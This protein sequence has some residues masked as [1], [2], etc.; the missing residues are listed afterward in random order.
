MF[1][2]LCLLYRQHT[3]LRSKLKWF[4]DLGFCVENFKVE[5]LIVLFTVLSL[6]LSYYKVPYINDLL[7]PVDSIKPWAFGSEHTNCTGLLDTKGWNP[8]LLFFSCCSNGNPYFQLLDL[9][10]EME[11]I[12]YPDENSR[13]N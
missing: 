10:G 8:F 6:L 13:R 12:L 7:F 5:Q 11:K 9:P 1:L 4:P 3:P 2:I